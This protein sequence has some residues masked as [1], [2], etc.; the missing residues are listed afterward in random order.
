LRSDRSMP[1]GAAMAQAEVGDD[2]YG[3]DPTVNRLN[4]LPLRCSAQR[5]P[6]CASGTQSNLLGVM[7]QCER[8]DMSISWAS[9]AHVP[10]RGRRRSRAG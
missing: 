3:E 7:S 5:L 2:V 6:F 8:G 4:P 1:A 10:L 9:G